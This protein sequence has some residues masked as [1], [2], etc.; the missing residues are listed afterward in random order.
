MNKTNKNIT[1]EKN[2]IKT[3]QSID[4]AFDILKALAYETDG[5]SRT[6]LSNKII[7]HTSTVYKML[8]VLNNRNYIDKN[9]SNNRYSL[10]LGFVELAR[11]RLK[12]LG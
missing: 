4:R 8:Q 11:L 6:E 2:K 7:L 9:E 5:L 1:E 3:N 12:S 10:G